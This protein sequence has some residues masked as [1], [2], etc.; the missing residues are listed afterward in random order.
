MFFYITCQRGLM[1]LSVRFTVEM[2]LSLLW[3][4]LDSQVAL[5]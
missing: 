4:L 1:V 5:M 2:K 3:K